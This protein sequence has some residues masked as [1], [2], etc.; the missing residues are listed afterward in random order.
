MSLPIVVVGAG[1]AGIAAGLE[2]Q[3]QRAPFVILEARDRV[4]GRAHTVERAGMPLDLG[5]E[6]LHHAETN[7]WVSRFEALGLPLDRGEAAWERAAVQATFPADMQAEHH[8]AFVALEARIDAAARTGADRA[9]GDLMQAGCRWN[10]LLNAFSAAYNGAAFSAISVED[11]AAYDD[12]RENWRAPGGYGAAI[13]RVAHDLPVRLASPVTRID[14][15]GRVLRVVGTFGVVEAAAVI[16]AVPTSLLASG[17]LGFDPPLSDKSKAAADLPLGHVSKVFLRLLGQEA[18]GEEQML[19]TEPLGPEPASFFLRGGGRPIAELYVGGALATAL[20][21]SGHAAAADFA[22]G[23]LAQA[24][25]SRIRDHAS[26]LAATGWSLDPWARGA[27]SHARV[28][29]RE[30]RAILAE[31]VDDRLFFAGEATHPTMFSTAHGAH[32]TGVAAARAVIASSAAR[33]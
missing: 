33:E 13:A 10:P 32:D 18:H 27:Y 21:R 4:G 31:P 3:A 5:C 15:G 16:V 24:Y 20:E 2:L 28:G 19:H 14:H 11:Y 22:I 1:A 23:R 26:A 8:R 25:G 30:A 7:S 9:A 6:W 29:R 17:A 12:G